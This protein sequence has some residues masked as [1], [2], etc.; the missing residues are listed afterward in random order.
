[1]WTDEMDTIQTWVNGGEVILKKVGREYSYRHA[2]ESGDWM[3]G[4][5][6]GMVWADAQALFED[7]L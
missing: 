3:Q 2:N 7:S 4:L 6:H 5:S 1:M